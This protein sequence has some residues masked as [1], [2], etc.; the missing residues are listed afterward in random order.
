MVLGAMREDARTWDTQVLLY[1]AHDEYREVLARAGPTVHDAVPKTTR[2]TEVERHVRELMVPRLDALRRLGQ[3]RLEETVTLD[4]LGN[5]GVTWLLLALE[6]TRSTCLVRGA[7]AQAR[8]AL[9]FSDGRLVQA[10]GVFDAG[11]CAGLDALRLVLASRPASVT[12]EPATVPTGEGFERH[13]T[14]SIVSVVVQRLAVEQ[15]HLGRVAVSDVFAVTVNEPLY[16]LYASVGSPAHRR[17]AHALCEDHVPPGELSGRLGLPQETVTGVL[18]EL[19]RR[20][21]IIPMLA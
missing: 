20:G 17:V 2:L 10:Q 3:R 14:G 6:S 13:P 9:W 5:I 12:I 4:R 21:V 15:H 16:Q 11:R 7:V 18:R 19:V 8:F 1:S